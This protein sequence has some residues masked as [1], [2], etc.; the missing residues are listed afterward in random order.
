[1]GIERGRIGQGSDQDDGSD[2]T[3]RFQ[4][5]DKSKVDTT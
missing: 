1:M 5:D 4:E 2:Q 3:S